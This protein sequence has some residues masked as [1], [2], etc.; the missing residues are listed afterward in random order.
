MIAPSRPVRLSGFTPATSDWFL[1]TFPQPTAV[2]LAAWSAIAAQHC[3]LVI[4]PTGSGKTLAAFLHA[5]DRL[6]EERDAAAKA[7]Q[8]PSKPTTR[9]LYISPIKALGSD[10]Q[11]NLN[12][13]LQGVSA[14]RA[15][16]GD[17]ALT[18][19]VGMRT[20]DT[21]Q[22][23]R[24]R[25]LRRPPDILITTPES[26]YLMLT[27][28]ARETLRGVQTVIVDEVHAVAGSKRGSHLA[29]SLE[30]LDALLPQPA[31]RIG[32]SATVRPVDQVARF[33]GGARPVTVVN[34]PSSR[35]LEVRIVV[36]VED[37]SD[38]SARNQSSISNT[39][40]QAGSIWPHV[41]ASIL[42]QVLKQRSTLVFT[43]ARGLAEK[44]TARL[45][46]LYAEQLS[47]SDPPDNSSPEH[48]V[49]SA[50]GTTRRTAGELPLIARAHH[51]SV[52]KEQR[53]DIESALKSGELRCVVATS[54]LELGIDM[55]L[56]DLVIQVAAP[57]PKWPDAARLRTV[58]QCFG[59]VWPVA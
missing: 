30:R 8:T 49:S 50:G 16:R 14:Q 44:L 54:S 42:Q 11:R 21:P 38:L 31:Q 55:G 34:P 13:P 41:E 56:V 27:S 9:V 26:L 39:P 22:A 43:N 20:G 10:V 6:F 19:S 35:Q 3:A 23:E 25:L 37:M 5:I 36:P 53:A 59:S 45:N 51:G 18:I 46:E 40:G 47:D 17:S 4:A 48:F 28:K 7:D 32:L 29:L 24:A 33:L 57:S 58:V 52:S 12:L 1:S 2:Q 15:L